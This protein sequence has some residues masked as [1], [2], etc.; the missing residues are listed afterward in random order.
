MQDCVAASIDA[1][2]RYLLNDPENSVFNPDHFKDEAY[3][4]AYTG[5]TSADHYVAFCK[6][7]GLT[8]YPVTSSSPEELITNA[9]AMLKDGHPVIF[10]EVD[11][12]VDTSLPEYK[13]W[14]HVCVWYADDAQGMTALDPWL[15]R[16]LYKSDAGWQS[17]LRSLQVWTAERIEESSMLSTQAASNYFEARSDT[18]W[19][20]KQTNIDVH[21]AILA[22]YRAFGAGQGTYN[23]LSLLGL[24]LSPETPVPGKPGVTLQRF[25]RGVVAYDPARIYDTPPGVNGPCYLVHIDALYKSIADLQALNASLNQ[26][27]ATHVCQPDPLDSEMRAALRGL[28]PIV[29]KV[30]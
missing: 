9:H 1:V 19:T 14:M 20:C 5:G 3:G 10:T 15:A 7:L 16:P 11:P 22:F 29:A 28:T 13:D 12:Y 8:L 17:V 6:S 2:C 25:E 30:Q 26:Q 23:G 24:P 4:E 27:I 18:V 21:D